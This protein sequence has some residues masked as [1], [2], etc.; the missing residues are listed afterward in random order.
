VGAKCPRS[1][2]AGEGDREHR[3]RR[4]DRIRDREQQPVESDVA[5]GGDHRHR[6][7]H[8]ACARDE[9]E[10]EARAEEEA[11]AE[12]SG[13]APRQR[14]QRPGKQLADLRHEEC[15]RD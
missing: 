12:I 2:L 7:E 4:T 1:S 15:E 9:D 5:L 6:C 10:S 14:L 11:A 13:T 8:R 3:Q